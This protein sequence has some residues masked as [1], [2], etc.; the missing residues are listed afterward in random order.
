MASLDELVSALRDEDIG[1]RAVFTL[2][3]NKCKGFKTSFRNKWKT[4][5][6]AVQAL[7]DAPNAYNVEYADTHMTKFKASYETLSDRYAFA[8]IVAGDDAANLEAMETRVSDAGEAFDE[9]E[10][11]YLAARTAA[12]PAQAAMPGVAPG[13]AGLAAPTAAALP[14]RSQAVQVGTGPDTG[15]TEVVGRKAEGIFR[16]KRARESHPP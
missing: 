1:D 10:Q 3:Q 5:S 2:A 14:R 15:R 11:R 7:E 8:I 6:T 12:V 16:V 4:A 13:A 9:L